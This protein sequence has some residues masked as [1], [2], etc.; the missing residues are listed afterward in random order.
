MRRERIF[1]FLGIWVA[2]LPYLGF[3]SSWKSILFTV[4]GMTLVYYSY[5]LY[6]ESKAKDKKEK[7]FDN[8]SENR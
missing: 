3:P 1:L 8:F 4:S 5:G 6:K 2:V 7:T